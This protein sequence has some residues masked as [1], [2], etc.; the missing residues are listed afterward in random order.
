ML[1]RAI[2]LSRSLLTGGSAGDAGAAGGRRIASNVLVQFSARAI[3]MSISVATV[4][5]TARTLHSSGYG[6]WTAAGS[7]VGIF[8]VLTDFGLTTVAMQRMAA[9]PEREHEW[10]GAL[11]SARVALS[12]LIAVLCAASIPIF[13]N[14]T[15][16]RRTVTFIMLVSVLSGS[17]SA[18][19]AVF[20][21]RLRA[22]LVLS[23]SVLQ[24]VIWLAIVAS[25]AATDASLISFAITY[26]ALNALVF[27][28]QVRTGL[29]LASVA[30]RAGIRLWRTLAR[31]AIPIGIAS[32]LITIYYQI[33]SVLL[34]QMAGPSET[35]VYG[36]AY[37]FI[38]P[39]T[40]LPSAVMSSFYP[41]IAAVFVHDQ[42]RA[43]RLVQTC[44]ELMAL[45]ALPILAGAI[46]LSDQIVHFLYGPGYARSGGLLPILMTAFVSICF[47]TLAGF[48]APVLRLQWR[49]ALYSAIGAAV[50]IALNLILIPSYGAYGSAWATVA[51]EVLTM[52]LMLSTVLYALRLRLAPWNILRTVA[53]AAAMTGVMLAAKPLGLIPAGLLGVAFY[54]VGVFATKIVDLNKLRALRAQPTTAE[55]VS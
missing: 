37:T 2:A 39:L 33:D 9:E 16:G 45:I 28:L 43:R 22:G 29:R 14:P 21:S 54:A 53:L 36:A 32:V 48:L 4:S 17:G 46:A 34:V 51:T 1:A 10:L 55:T 6:V 25:L 47:G 7:Y 40:F 12:I 3:T 24:S 19:M 23:F 50:N 5:L 42:G 31:V 11:V 35:G 30:W 20:S 27:A 38:G 15:D 18:L 8:S 44:A 26:S 49:L 13:L 52:T 41:V